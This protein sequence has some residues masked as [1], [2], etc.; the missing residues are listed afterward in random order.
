MGIRIAS[1]SLFC[2]CKRL[3]L[4]LPTLKYHL[5]WYN[6][7]PSAIHTANNA[8]LLALCVNAPDALAH[9]IP[10]FF[11]IA[12][13]NTTKILR[14][15]LRAAQNDTGESLLLI[16]EWYYGFSVS[17]DFA[18]NRSFL[19]SSRTHFFMSFWAGQR[20]SRRIFALFLGAVCFAHGM[21]WDFSF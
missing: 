10:C 1:Y 3:W 18:H 16:H 9:F 19:P 2:L 5:H 17:L 12:F 7:W 15:A 21:K 11:P 20:P 14:H 13:R 8:C 6:L 4:K